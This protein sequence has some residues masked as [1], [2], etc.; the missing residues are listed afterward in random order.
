MVNGFD[1]FI[2]LAFVICMWRGWRRG[3]VRVVYGLLSVSIAIFLAGMLYPMVRNGLMNTPVAWSIQ[4]WIVDSL[5]ISGLAASGITAQAQ[6]IEGLPLPEGLREMLI[7]NNNPAVYDVLGV[8]ALEEFIA[9]YITGLIINAVSAILVFVAV[10]IIMGQLSRNLRIFNR[11]PIIRGVNRS[12]GA[13]VGSIVG[14]VIVWLVLGVV[15]FFEGATTAQVPD[16]FY[17]A[18]LAPFFHQNNILVDMLFALG[19]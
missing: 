9:V 12:G 17:G 13:L 14:L 15:A 16:Q 2:V 1:V 19:F 5:G 10:L 18:L 4:N 3:L 6:A 8:G 7:I 11:I